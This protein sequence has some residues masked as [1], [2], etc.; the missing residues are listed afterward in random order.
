MNLI[1]DYWLE[2]LFGSLISVVTFL[3]K[4][5]SD[6]KKILSFTTKGVQMLLKCKIIENYNMYKKRGIITIYEKEIMNELYKEYENLGGNGII[7]YIKNELD[8]LPLVNE[9]VKNVIR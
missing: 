3:I 5:I 1:V 8:E 7:K 6:Y 9:E 2:F 4:K